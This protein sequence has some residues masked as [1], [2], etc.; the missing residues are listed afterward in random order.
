MATTNNYTL[1]IVLNE[2]EFGES[3]K[4]IRVFT[5]NYGK[6]SIMVKGAMTPK[7]KNLGVSQVFGVNEYLLKKGQNF[8]YI[9]DAK[10]VESNFKIRDD[11][12]NLIYASIL[13]EILEKSSIRGEANERV[14]DLMRKSLNFFNFTKDPISLA[15]AFELKYLSFIGYR[16]KLDIKEKSYFSVR[17]GIIDFQDPYSFSLSRRDLVYLN[18]LLY[19]KFEELEDMEEIDVNRKKYLHNII[20]KYIKYNLDI[21]SFKSDRLF[22]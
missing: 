22:N 4:I 14:F 11:Y 8:F 1:G 15:I 20:I 17:E 6:I 9:G 13:L 18:K 7:S 10:I 12:Y 19:N 21:S 5:R 2:M 3:S 16:P